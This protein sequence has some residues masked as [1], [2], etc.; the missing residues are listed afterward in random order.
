MISSRI[1]IYHFFPKKYIDLRADYNSLV[2]D[3]IGYVIPDS[4]SRT[5]YQCREYK[6][7]S[8]AEN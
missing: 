2:F 8:I 4:N 1:D 3:K 7:I 5:D 6:R